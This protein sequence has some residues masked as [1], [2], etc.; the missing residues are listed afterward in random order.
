M[1][2]RNN[3]PSETWHG[4]INLCVSRDQKIL[5]D[6]AARAVGRSSSEFIL[7]TACSKATAVLLDRIYF[8]VE[9]KAFE[10]FA[11]MLDKPLAEDRNLSRLLQTKPPWER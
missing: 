3:S 10:R 5:I 7:D 4:T 2:V 9:E 6:H 1:P 11:D 8:V